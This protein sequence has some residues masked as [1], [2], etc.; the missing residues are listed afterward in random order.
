MSNYGP[1]YPSSS[2]AIVRLHEIMRQTGRARAENKQSTPSLGQPKDIVTLA[3]PPSSIESKL[4]DA[5]STRY[6]QVFSSMQCRC[7]RY[8][9]HRTTD[10]S[11]KKARTKDNFSSRSSSAGVYGVSS[12]QSLQAMLRQW[13][14]GEQEEHPR[15]ARNR[16]QSG[17]RLCW[18]AMEQT[19]AI[20]P[21][22]I[23]FAAEQTM[24][25]DWMCWGS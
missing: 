19:S 3:S 6:W 2:P 15:S 7:Q 18:P 13:S 25:S 4:K 21:V 20:F 8:S 14:K 17:H 24:N 5:H 9:F 10:R 1:P 12:K 16:C 22:M 23:D 11:Q